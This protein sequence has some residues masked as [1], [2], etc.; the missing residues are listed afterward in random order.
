MRSPILLLHIIAGTLGMLSGFV[1]AFLRKGS[2]Q[3]GRAGNIFVVAMLSLSST[4]VLLAIMKSQPGNVLGGTLTFYL[5]A[6]AWMTARRSDGEPGT[7]DWGALLV[8]LGL[9]AVEVTCGLEA[10]MS[11]K[12]LKYGYPA[13]SYF[14]LGSV[15]VLATTGD[16]R[17]L[18]RGGIAGKQRIARHLWRMCFALFIAAASIFMARQQLFPDLLRKTGVLLFLSFLP[19]MLMIFWLVRVRFANAY[20]RMSIPT[21]GDAYSQRASPPS[22]RRDWVWLRQRLS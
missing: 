6:T 17:M 15:A 3:H 16:I 22:S 9:A 19:L 12:G 13:G 18:V 11:P 2:R 5:V 4:G 21:S 14:F 20:K 10:A 8:V 1:A 7:F